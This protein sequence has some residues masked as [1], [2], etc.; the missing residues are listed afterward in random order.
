MK[1]YFY[2]TDIFLTA[3]NGDHLFQ[4]L[5]QTLTR[6]EGK[7]IQPRW[8]SKR[9]EKRGGYL[10]NKVSQHLLI[11]GGVSGDLTQSRTGLFQYSLLFTQ[12]TQRQIQV[13]HT[14]RMCMQQIVLRLFSFRSATTGHKTSIHHNFI[15]TK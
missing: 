11:A 4:Q 8:Q 12:Q 13:V 3:T 9:M 15:N 5:K 2:E 10:G 6:I 7:T 14:V 1:T